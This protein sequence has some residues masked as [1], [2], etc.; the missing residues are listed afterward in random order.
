MIYTVSHYISLPICWDLY[1]VCWRKC[2]TESTEIKSAKPGGKTSTC[3]LLVVKILLLFI[4][5]CVY[6]GHCGIGAYTWSWIKEYTNIPY[7]VAKHNN[8]A[9]CDVPAG[10]ITD[11]SLGHS[12][13]LL[14]WSFRDVEWGVKSPNSRSTGLA[15]VKWIPWVEQYYGSKRSSALG[16]LQVHEWRL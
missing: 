10:S 12:I 11:S 13:T 14:D 8:S 3:R 9:G 1:C 2:F 5:G 6:S 7:S 15:V 4:P 16:F